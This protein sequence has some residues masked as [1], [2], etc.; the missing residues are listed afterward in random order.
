MLNKEG[1]S[2]VQDALKVSD[3]IGGGGGGKPRD[4]LHFL[5]SLDFSSMFFLSFLQSFSLLE[6]KMSPGRQFVSEVSRK[7]A[8]ATVQINY[9]GTTHPI[10]VSSELSLS[11][12]YEV[13]RGCV[14]IEG[15][16]VQT[17]VML[18]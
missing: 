5:V 7:E 6:D 2:S 14:S 10:K 8:T 17:N 16:S 11:G 12:G 15:G 9:Q 1:Q 4:F 13:W 3:R 18:L